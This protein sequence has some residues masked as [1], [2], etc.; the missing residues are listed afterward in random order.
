MEFVL[1]GVVIFIIGIFAGFGVGKMKYHQWPIG[2]LRVDQSDP[3]SPPHLFLELDENVPTIMSKKKC[4]V[5]RQGGGLHPA[6]ITS[7]I[8]EPTLN[9]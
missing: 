6:R 2:D 7:A 3:D 1:F 9:F 4:H 8:M 5:P